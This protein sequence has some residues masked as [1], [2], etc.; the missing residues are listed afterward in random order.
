MVDLYCSVC[1]EVISTASPQI[2]AGNPHHGCGGHF[3]YRDRQ[4]RGC[5]GSCVFKA[6]LSRKAYDGFSTIWCAKIGQ[7]AL[8]ISTSCKKYT[9]RG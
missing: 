5:L 9:K 2:F 8:L 3:E 1:S 6:P 7:E 4:N